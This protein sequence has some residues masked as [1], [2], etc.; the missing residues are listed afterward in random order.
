ME[1]Q[2]RQIQG[3]RELNSSEIASM[4]SWK[5]LEDEILKMLDHNLSEGADAR[6]V[7]IART[8]F[9]KACMFA[10]RAV[11]RPQGYPEP[12]KTPLSEVTD[13][14]PLRTK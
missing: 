4:N 11:A 7:A 9:Q 14:G 3:Y 10:G 13:A 5:Y 1:N 12:E 8:A 6:W 2:H